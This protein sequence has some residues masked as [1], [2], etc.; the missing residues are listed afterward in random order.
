MR[1][2]RG[3]SAIVQAV[4]QCKVGK[5]ELAHN[6]TIFLDE[7]GDMQPTVQV[8]LMRVLQEKEVERIGGGKPRRIDF[9]VISATNRNLDQMVGIGRFRLDLYYR[10]NVITINLPPLRKISR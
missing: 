7:I 9:R 10:L 6:G 1:Q 4:K 5:F 8:K 3:Y 2:G